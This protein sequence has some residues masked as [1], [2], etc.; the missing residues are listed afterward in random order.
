VALRTCLESAASNNLR[1]VTA[2]NAWF[3]LQLHGLPTAGKRAVV[4]R[5][6]LLVSE[7]QTRDLIAAQYTIDQSNCYIKYA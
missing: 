3:Q 7:Q 5:N 1:V 6:T 4:L 2:N